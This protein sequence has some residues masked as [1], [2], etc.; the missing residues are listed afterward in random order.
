M[1][2]DTV[3]LP[4]PHGNGLSLK[5]SDIS[6]GKPSN[7]LCQTYQKANTRGKNKGNDL[8]QQSKVSSLC[9]TTIQN[10]LE[11]TL[12]EKFGG[13]KQ[14]DPLRI[15]HRKFYVSKLA[16]PS[17]TFFCLFSLFSFLTFIGEQLIQNTKRYEYC[18]FMHLAHLLLCSLLES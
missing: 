8:E 10:N 9:E 4:R 12:K 7:I 15:K 1:G 6:K 2:N 16:L 14:Q 11:F 5:H 18:I 17:I 13:K 3:A